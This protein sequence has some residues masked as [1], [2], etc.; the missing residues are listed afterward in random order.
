MADNFVQHLTPVELERLKD[1]K[2]DVSY[3]R[4]HVQYAQNAVRKIE[5]LARKRAEKTTTKVDAR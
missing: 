2:A 4:K 3:Y 1:A 5:N